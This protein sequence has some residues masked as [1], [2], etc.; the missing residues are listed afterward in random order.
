[1][2]E[3]LT[4]GRVR[5]VADAGDPSAGTIQPKRIA[6]LTYLALAVGRTSVRCDAL[7]ALFWPELGEEEGRHALRQALH[8]L[9]HVI[10]DDVF[11]TSGDELGLRDGA[12]RCDA[13]L[14]DQ[15]VDSG[16][17]SDALDVYRGDFFIGFHVDDVSSEYEEWVERTRGRLKR[18]AAAAA[19]A[20]SDEA[21]RGG[22]TTRAIDLGR[23]ACELEPDQEAGWRRLMTLQ[24]AAPVE[25]RP[26]PTDAAITRNAPAASSEPVR[27]IVSPRAT[28]IA[29]VLATT[30]LVAIGAF[31][32]E[33]NERADD[34][35]SLIATGTL[36]AKDRIVVADF[37]NL[38]GDTLLAAAVT[39]AFRMD[40]SQSPLVTVLTR[41]QVD[42]ALTRMER[43]PGLTLD[44]SLAR[45]VAVREGAKAV[46]TGSIGKIGTAYTVSVQLVSADRGDPLATFRETAADSAGL[47]D[48]VDRTSKQLRHRIGE[49]LRDVVPALRAGRRGA[50]VGDDAA[51]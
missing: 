34:R 16:K 28:T 51:R 1:M 43:Q 18:R 8:Y 27:P 44:D 5:L 40:L 20:A 21:A 42:S 31:A 30:V 45:D 46:V 32:W 41:R 33:R 14:F 37:A 2:G 39:E 9:R 6:L 23:R 19:W 10:G 38:A 29:V 3:L 24:H 35:P 7:V 49:T 48:A 36:A 15:L 12:I 26:A 13:I 4:L 47:I 17:A 25:S 50:R 11:T 22:D